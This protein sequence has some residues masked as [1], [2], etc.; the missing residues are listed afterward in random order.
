MELP[1]KL[2][3]DVLE[4]KIVEIVDTERQNEISIDNRLDFHIFKESFSAIS[5]QELPCVNIIFLK[6]ET[7]QG[8]TNKY[9]TINIFFEIQ[10][11]ASVYAE[12]EKTADEL[13]AKRLFYLAAQVKRAIAK[14]KNIDFGFELGTFSMRGIP[15]FQRLE[16]IKVSDSE[17]FVAVGKFEIQIGASYIPEDIELASLLEID[18]NAKFF[19]I[20]KIYEK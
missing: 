12:N 6:E 20:K 18:L 9:Q 16:N 2:L 3:F 5:L 13:S 1:N 4:D 10:L 8:D 7:G 19:E 11:F 15:V 14:L 17:N